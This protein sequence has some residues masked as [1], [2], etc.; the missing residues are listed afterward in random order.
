MKFE[1]KSI[2]IDLCNLTRD[3]RGD[4]PVSYR[5]NIIYTI[6]HD[7]GSFIDKFSRLNRVSSIVPN[8]HVDSTLSQMTEYRDS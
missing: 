6:E 2:E 1:L 3:E 8:G 4:G 7:G 5:G